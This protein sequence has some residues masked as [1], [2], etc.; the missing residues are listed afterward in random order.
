[1]A[2]RSARTKDIDA[3]RSLLIAASLPAADVSE[4]SP[5]AFFVF[6]DD[7]HEIKGCV[8]LEVYGA[9]GLLRSLAVRPDAQNAG[10]GQILVSNVE[11]AAALQAIGQLYLLTTSASDFFV[12]SGYEVVD[13]ESAPEAI[14]GTLQFAE[15]CPASATFMTKML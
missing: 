6:E 14:R 13:R 3:I 8:G 5:I 9:V 2:V 15:L 1:M 7:R 4:T 10:I 11:E 12:R